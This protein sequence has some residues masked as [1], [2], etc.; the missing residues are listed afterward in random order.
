MSHL[1]TILT[2]GGTGFIGS[3]LFAYFLNENY[4]VRCLDD[5]LTLQ[6]SNIE[7][8][9]DHP[10]AEFLELNSLDCD[11]YS[12]A[13]KG[14]DTVS[15]KAALGSV[16]RSINNP[17]A[18]KEINALGFLKNMLNAARDNGVKRFV[19]SSSS[20]EY[21][22]TIPKFFELFLE[23]KSPEI[24]GGGKQTR[25]LAYISNMSH[26]NEQALISSNSEGFVEVYNV[27]YGQSCEL[28]ILIRAI[29]KKLQRN[30]TYLANVNSE[31]LCNR[32]GDVKYSF[33]DI[34]KLNDSLGYSVQYSFEEGMIM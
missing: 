34:S 31:Y 4:K 33:S 25:D 12:K 3:N 1:K 9:L 23:D 7:R 21:T 15:N 2:A 14:L 11:S 18:T 16:P 19:Y 24:H 6:K 20:S 10:N 26:A 28:N 8:L 13:S 30:E 27:T 22:A 17:M 29:K 32:K 5:L